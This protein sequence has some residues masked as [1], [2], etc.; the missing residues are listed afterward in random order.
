[1]TFPGFY[2]Q[3]M[4]NA[5][6][7]DRP[8]FGSKVTIENVTSGICC[9]NDSIDPQT[10]LGS[11]LLLPA[12]D[13]IPRVS[14]PN[15]QGIGKGED[16]L[17]HGRNESPGNSQ[18]SSE[19]P[20]SYGSP[21]TAAVSANGDDDDDDAAAGGLDNIDPLLFASP[22]PAT[23]LDAAANLDSPPQSASMAGNMEVALEDSPVADATLLVNADMAGSMGLDFA[24]GLT[25]PSSPLQHILRPAANPEEQPSRDHTFKAWKRKMEQDISIGHAELP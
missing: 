5:A 23:S 13:D 22:S 19:H 2:E 21:R 10:F 8:P 20:S 25:V 7:H 4:R 18:G 1:M 6:V 14:G 11:Y 9:I 17:E 12:C 3:L 24:T 16:D 15:S